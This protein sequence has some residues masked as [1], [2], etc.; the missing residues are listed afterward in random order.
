MKTLKAV[1]IIIT[2]QG[3]PNIDYIVVRFRVWSSFVYLDT[4]F[5]DFLSPTQA[6][7]DCIC[8]LFYFQLHYSSESIPYCHIEEQR[9]H[10]TKSLKGVTPFARTALSAHLIF[11]HW[12]LMT[13]LPFI[14]FNDSQRITSEYI[15]MI[16]LREWQTTMKQHARSLDMHK[17]FIIKH[18]GACL[19]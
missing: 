16:C 2:F 17:D 5:W 6:L 19:Q 11:M 9:G 13:T 15:V 3:L 1:T 12:P 14:P 7:A 18:K 10:S 4:I 8:Y